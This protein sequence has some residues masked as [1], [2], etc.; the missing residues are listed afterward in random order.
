LAVLLLIID[1]CP[2]IGESRRCKKRKKLY[3][4]S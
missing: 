4:R 2:I 3:R 1:L